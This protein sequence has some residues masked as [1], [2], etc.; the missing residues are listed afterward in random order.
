MER[1]LA[2]E[3]RVGV[4]VLLVL[5]LL[6]AITWAI[7]GGLNSIK[8]RYQ[9]HAWYIDVQGLKAGAVVRLAGIT[10]GEVKAVDLSDEREGKNVHVLL[11]IREE[12]MEKIRGDSVASI[13]SVG[14]LGDNL[15]TV[16]VGKTGEP[17]ADGADIV[18][19]EAEG[20]L[21]PLAK[22]GP[23]LD[24][25]KNITGK[26]DLMLGTDEEAR[27]ARIADSFN[28]IEGLLQGAKDG[29]GVLHVLLYDEEAG[30]KVDSILT[31]V[32]GIT[33]DVKGITNEVRHGDGLAHEV[34]YGEGGKALATNLTTLASSVNGVVDDL[35][36]KDSL[37]HAILYDPEQKRM[38]DDL[39]VLA[40]NLRSISESVESGEGT[41]GLLIRDPQLYEDIRLLFGGA[42]RNALLRAYVRSTVARSRDE[43]GTGLPDA[44]Q[45]GP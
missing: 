5:A 42:Q 22:A 39:R 3:I 45:D 43:Q 28:H 6:A 7:G 17:L 15:I 23:I 20:L 1:N 29:R 18:S 14:V 38:V 11:E 26:L 40:G 30:R 8:P 27:G 36:T 32:N 9:L 35:K 12:Y 10:V 44:P 4:F 24:N 37:A 31:D 13:S 41:A 19:A 2:Q 25:A 34:I 33:S 16:S 21:G